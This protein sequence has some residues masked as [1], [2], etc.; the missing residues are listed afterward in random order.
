MDDI[1]NTQPT[2]SQGDMLRLT[3]VYTIRNYAMLETLMGAQAKIMAHNS[4]K[5]VKEA[6][7]ILQDQSSKVEIDVLREI[8]QKYG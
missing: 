1:H 4:G 8:L 2:I 6:I 5:P 3:Y 7:R